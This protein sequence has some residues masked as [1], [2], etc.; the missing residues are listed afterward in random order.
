VPVEAKPLFRPDV[1]HPLLSA[2]HLGER[3]AA[4]REI[5]S[6]WAELLYSPQADKLKEQELLPD[7]LADLFCQVLGHTRAVDNK[8]RFTFSREKYV[9]VDGKYADAV[10]GELRPGHERFLIA[11]EGKGPKDPLDRPF[12]GRKMSAV[13]QGYR[14]AINLPCDWIIVTSMRQTRLYYKGADQYTYERFDIQSLAKDE[15]QLKKFVFLLGA[16]RVVPASGQSHLYELLTTSERVGREL[17]KEFYVRYA[18]MREDAFEHLCRDN[19]EVPPSDLLASTQKLLDRI[20]FCSFCEDRGLLPTETIRRAYEHSDPY[21]PHPIWENF[22]GLFKAVNLGNTALNIP[23]YNGGLFADDP[24]LERLKV[25]DEICRYFQDLADYDYRPPH[26]ATDDGSG[27][28]LVDVDILGHIFEQSI[29]DLE[30]LKNELEGLT[31]R[32]GREQH[33][34]RRKKEGAFYTPAFITRYIVGEALGRV[35][36]EKFE[37]LRARHAEEAAGTARRVLANPRSYDPNALNDPQTKALTRF[38]FA[39]Q[40][41]LAHLKILDPSCGSGAFLI[42]AFEQ[43]Y[44]AYEHSNDRLEDLRGERWLFDL[45]RQ[46]LQNNL[47]GVDLNDEAIQICRLSLWIK[48]ARRGKALTSLDHTIRVGNSVVSDPAVHPRAFD[49]QTAFPEVF[50]QG[51][52]DVVIGNPPYVRGDWITAYKPYLKRHYQTFDGSADLYVYFYELGLRLLK[53]GAPLSFVVTNKWMKAAYAERLRRFFAEQCWVESLVNFGHAKQIFEDA[54]VFPSI[55]VAR[56]PA[57]GTGPTAARVCAIPREQ[58]RINDLAVQIQEKGYQ[59]EKTRLGPAPWMLEPEDMMAVLAKIRE[60]RKTLAEYVGTRP[61]TGI[62]TGLNEAFLISSAKRDALVAEHPGCAD[63]IRPY[64]RGENIDRWHSEWAGEWM[65]ALKSSQNFRWP[66]SDG[67]N[68][69]EQ[70]FAAT[71]PS[72]YGHFKGLEDRLRA[73]Q[74]QGVYWWELRSCTYWPEFERPKI[75]YQEIQF[76]PSYAA[77][78]TGQLANNKVFFIASSDIY[79]LTVL[80]SPLLWWYNWCYLPHM[81]DEALSPAIYLLEHLPIAEPTDELRSS[82]QSVAARLVA[83]KREHQNTRRELLDWLRAE[84]EVKTFSAALQ[85]PFGLDLETFIREVRAGRGRRSTLSVAAHR[86]LKEEHERLIRP[87]Q[88]L[89]KETRILEGQASDLVNAAYGLNAEEVQLI[90]DTAPP[91]MPI[92]RPNL[93]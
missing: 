82:I 5:L 56:R 71:Y 26:E 83:I 33:T 29:S 68:D 2:F 14:Y 66:W 11:V 55:I 42:E 19:P 92:T 15:S 25:T 18:D 22:R 58:L 51:G 67:G 34:S 47:Y 86:S 43:L 90:W 76:H 70:V 45:D 7:F 72:I 81:K 46:I 32:Q 54:D 35:L 91:R 78:E 17:T 77:D 79:L 60:R 23:A 57:E 6:R 85:E 80:N 64:L 8:D 13:D 50:D 89:T 28:R 69:A 53:P 20:L 61:N 59:V 37:A 62:K 4:S 38:W 24:E 73:R 44:Q 3:A 40:D 65:I 1:L 75:V 88:A 93:A 27:A 49:W 63:I 10:I 41:E 48:T 52:F 36:E 30:R 9:Q 12:A 16:H 84:H 39:W 87:A 31:E 21:N 74:D